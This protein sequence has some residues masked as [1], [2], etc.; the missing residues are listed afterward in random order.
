[1]L[2]ALRQFDRDVARGA[3][4]AGAAVG[5][6]LA[7]DRFQEQ[8]EFFGKH[9]RRLNGWLLFPLVEAIARKFNQLF[10]SAMALDQFARSKSASINDP[11]TRLPR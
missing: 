6:A 1:M 3:D 10:E 11:R 4:H 8:N 5:V 2:L 9:V 7:L